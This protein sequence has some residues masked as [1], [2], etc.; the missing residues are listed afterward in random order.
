[1]KAERRRLWW[2]RTGDRVPRV[3]LLAALV[4][5][6]AGLSEAQTL[7]GT[8]F[9]DRDGDGIVDPGEPVLAGVMVDLSGTSVCR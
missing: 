3:L 4:I 6:V 8:I 5:P 9:E 1:M 7:T 2:R